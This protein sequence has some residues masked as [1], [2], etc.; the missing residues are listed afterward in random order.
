MAEGRLGRWSRL[1]RRGGADAREERQALEDEE[2]AAKA[3]ASATPDAV[4][5]PGGVR[6]RNFVPAMPPLAPEAEDGDDRF[7][8]GIGHAEQPRDPVPAERDDTGAAPEVPEDDEDERPLSEDEKKIVETL[9][10]IESLTADSDITPF[11]KN[12]VPEFIKQRALRKMWRITP[13]FGFR[14]GLDDY[15]EDFN[16]IDKLIPA[17]TGN[18]KVGRGFLS[19]EELQD[20]MPEEAKRAFDEDEDEDENEDGEE[21]AEDARA[22]ASESAPDS[23]GDAAEDPPEG[24]ET[25]EAED[26]ETGR[27]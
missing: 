11:M 20:M 8:R 17:G 7:S 3:R 21:G 1:K 6:V 10:P 4:R 19:E 9:P 23:G 26:G 5:L 13:L 27:H 15:D 16:V 2:R 14:D 22:D 25:A 12:G 18:Y 24:A